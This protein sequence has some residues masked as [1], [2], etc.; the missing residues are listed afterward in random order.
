MYELVFVDLLLQ[1]VCRER[2]HTLCFFHNRFVTVVFFASH[3]NLL[4]LLYF[5]LEQ[6]S[7]IFFV[8]RLRECKL[9]FLLP[10]NDSLR[11]VARDVS[12]VGLHRHT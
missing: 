11:Q 2:N 9:F 4:L 3:G 12:V 10:S 8:W 6:T 1:K 5:L 7:L